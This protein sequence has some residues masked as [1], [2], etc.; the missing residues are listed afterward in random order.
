MIQIEY[1]V[2]R[3]SFI[4][5]LLY[6]IIYLSTSTIVSFLFYD[7]LIP[8]IVII[9]FIII[10]YKYI[11]NFLCEKRKDNLIL[12][13]RDMLHSVSAS[14]NSGYSIENSI[15]EA[16]NEMTIL[17]GRTS[18]ICNEIDLML[19]KLA[20]NIPVQKIFSDFS[21]RSQCSDIIIFS[22]ILTI[23]KRNGGDLIA[24]IRSS[25]RTIAEKIDIN[26]EI[27][28]ALSS[29]KYEQNIMF[30]MPIV[31]MI[32]IRLSS[33]GFFEPVYHNITGI[34]IMSLCLIIYISA[35]VIGLKL[36]T[37]KI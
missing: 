18:Y 24:I 11:S 8:V 27:A 2:Y 35:V 13:F 37:V 20:I 36:S 6:G 25:S 29:R 22:Q 16:N 10:Y 17:Y 28:A 7:S 19:K 15:K 23:A 31:I 9:P 32:Y 26:R 12:Q 21:I 14:L 30:L 33:D 4:E 3:L 5:Y 34:L 1:D